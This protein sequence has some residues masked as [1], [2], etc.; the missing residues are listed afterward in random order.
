MLIHEK[1]D[2]RKAC[3]ARVVELMSNRH[4]KG[5]V[6]CSSMTL[7][8]LEVYGPSRE[9]PG[10]RAKTSFKPHGSGSKFIRWTDKHGQGWAASHATLSGHSFG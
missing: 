2:D 9:I 3:M 1:F 6:G 8:V 10:L 7:A 5:W 4:D